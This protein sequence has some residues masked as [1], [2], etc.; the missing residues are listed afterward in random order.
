MSAK[1]SKPERDLN[2]SMGA[3]FGEVYTLICPPCNGPWLEEL[4]YNCFFS[5][6]GE[7]IAKVRPRGAPPRL[8]RMEE[9]N[10]AGYDR[11]SV[12]ADP[13]FVDAANYDYRVRPE[14][15]AL[16]LGFVNFDMGC[17]GLTE[18]FPSSWWDEALRS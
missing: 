2:F 14:S 3:C 17:W 18:A 16:K 4:D 5:D 8:Y 15:P 6:V 10:A 11:H 1:C 9:W 13:L 7:F 12:F